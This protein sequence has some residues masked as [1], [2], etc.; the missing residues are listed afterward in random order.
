MKIFKNVFFTINLSFMKKIYPLFL[1]L[2]F[3]SINIFAQKNS[4]IFD[5]ISYEFSDYLADRILEKGKDIQKNTDDKRT[6][7][8][9]VDYLYNSKGQQTQLSQ[10]L[11]YRI[12]NYL[13][14]EL[15]NV[16]IS[17]H[18]FKVNS[19]YD[20]DIPTDKKITSTLKQDYTLTGQYVILNN[21]ISFTKFTLTHINSGI[22][23]N[24]S[25]KYV[26]TNNHKI[27]KEYDLKP[28]QP[29]FFKQLM[30]IKKDNTLL[31]SIHLTTNKNNVKSTII[32]GIGQVYET[33]FDTDYN[34]TMNL[35]KDA[36]IYA[37]FYDP[38]DSNNPFIWVIDENN[39]QYK[40]GIYEDFL[41]QNLNFYKTAKS[42]KYNYVKLIISENKID[43]EKYYTKKFI[44]G[45]ESVIIENTECEQLINNLS[46]LNNI[47]TQTIILT[48]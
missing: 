21:K 31:K 5:D 4:E 32:D 34:F 3:S 44:E 26:F 38:G 14:K 48:F 7:S 29:N 33:K 10:E 23:Y 46:S 36:Y 22:I 19:P 45:D 27:L 25:D 16:V 8:I 47:Q 39:T 41:S 2:L 6:I 15:N 40:K 11:G 18:S 28:L 13:Q 37:F 43:I 20:F 9:Q 1:L 35:D 24:F 17:R 30:D 12:A 42:G